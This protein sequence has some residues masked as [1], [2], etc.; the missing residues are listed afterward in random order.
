MKPREDAGV[1]TLGRMM[2]EMIANNDGNQ[3]L[4]VKEEKPLQ[5][6]DLPVD[7]LNDIIQ[8]ITHT[9]D[10]TSL[11]LTHSALHALAIP[12][13]YSRFDIVWPD[14]HNTA[15]A[16]AGVDALTFG[17]ATL[18]MGEDVFGG[19]PSTVSP[20]TTSP[21][22]YKCQECGA[23]NR[24]RPVHDVVP[25]APTYAIRSRQSRRGNSFSYFT[26]KFSLGN[27][28]PDWVA[29]YLI[30]KESGKMLG[31]LV[32][33]ALARMPNLETFI[34][35]MPTGVVR[36]IWLALASLAQRRDGMPCRLE[37]VWVRWHDNSKAHS[38]QDHSHTHLVTE[39][40][41]PLSS[42]HAATAVGFLVPADEAVSTA[43]SPPS[44]G[45]GSPFH[46]FV[47]VEHPTFSVLP[48]LKS[49]SVLD[50][51]EL[52]YLD[53]MSLLVERSRT[54]L[55]EMRIGI[56]Q[57]AKAR[58]WVS[59]WD[60]D[61]LQ[62]VD[63]NA[64]WP[65]LCTIGRK[66][67]GGVL[68]VLFG[69][70]YDLRQTKSHQP[71]S[72]IQTTN[73]TATAETFPDIGAPSVLPADKTPVH[74]VLPLATLEKDLSALE[75][76]ESEFEVP[77]SLGAEQSL[78]TGPQSN[79]HTVQHVGTNAVQTSEAYSKFGPSLIASESS[80][81]SPCESYQ[82]PKSDKA[83][84]PRFDIQDCA[85]PFAQDLDSTSI[86]ADPGGAK[87][88]GTVDPV[89]RLTATSQQLPL[90]GVLRLEI[91]ELERVP[92]C[93]PILQEALDWSLLTSLTILSCPNH[94]FLW[95]SMRRRFN[96]LQSRSIAGLAVRNGHMPPMMK[97][98]SH[99]E[100]SHKPT[101]PFPS[102][103]SYRL[104]LKK[105]HTDA[106]SP[107]LI[108]FLRDALAPNTLETL[109]LQDGGLYTSPVKVESI[110]RGPLKRH[111]ASLQKIMIESSEKAS[112]GPLA[113]GQ[114]WKKWILSREVLTFIT[115]GKMTNL[116]EMA[117]AIEYK[118]WR[119]PLIKQIRSL[120]VP[121][122]ANHIYAGNLDSK[123]LALQ[124]LDIVALRPDIELCYLGIA[125][126]C[127]EVMEGNR[128]DGNASF[129]GHAANPGAGAIAHGTA[130]D[131]EADIIDDLDEDIDA[132]ND[133]D[134]AGDGSD[135]TTSDTSSSSR[136]DVDDEECYSSEEERIE[137]SLRLREILFYD[138]KVAVFKARHGRL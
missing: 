86:G 138:D 53:E 40:Q 133:D 89:S 111:R 90:R 22:S 99:H 56:A 121:F 14:G 8:E 61:R 24:V 110:Y 81:S 49:L 100:P 112:N 108:S 47:R 94:D 79:A 78:I 21:Q 37:R 124:V 118:D 74:D 30:T 10:L 122:I 51:D 12:F 36:D 119:L 28:P 136:D 27:G 97:P 80:A 75:E 125:N 16:R 117:L 43:T 34:W 26:R 46:S 107:S 6:L 64:T 116:K 96:P 115:S 5:L 54:C 101:D 76:N 39:G 68:G 4:V 19:Y 87:S 135:D 77:F 85:M 7:I 17:L 63:Y 52:A 48:P 70:V 114:K 130:T 33:L 71:H 13:I 104:K 98:S 23:C 59:T 134:S 126:K 11:A 73:D 58:D 105:I 131:D 57:Q 82:T 66:R 60:G 38:P 9:N 92:L 29:E 91:L 102:A 32:A 3:P 67:L 137:P 42:S 25:D 127:F 35:D 88:A 15:E 31:T 113:T 103:S 50:I 44:V 20:S 132:D 69:R 120:Y 41:L 109:F 129:T 128:H 2:T 18:V 83:D 62:Q 45:N 1:N 93:V 106:V 84:T 65:G 95:K 55:R 123:D 72:Q